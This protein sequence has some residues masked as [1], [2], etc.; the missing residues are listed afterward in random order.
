MTA[1]N[2]REVMKEEANQLSGK[3][4]EKPPVLST[5]DQEMEQT[6]RQKERI[7]KER[8]QITQGESRVYRAEQKRSQRSQKKPTDSVETILQSGSGPKQI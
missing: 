7:E 6:R 5:E 3:T 1:S 4:E 8:K 2:F